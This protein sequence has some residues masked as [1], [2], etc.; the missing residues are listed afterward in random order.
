MDRAA[1]L[2][3]L[4]AKETELRRLGVRR[5]ALFG[6]VA[7]GDARPDSDIDLMIELDPA[8]RLGVFEFVGIVQFLEDLLPGQVDVSL[9]ERLKPVVRPAAERE[10]VYAF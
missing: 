6:S 3:V 8:A 9:R 4:R 2:S 7:R 10:A 5:L 1:I